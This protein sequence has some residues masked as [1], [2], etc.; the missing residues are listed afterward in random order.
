MSA[1]R[2]RRYLVIRSNG[3]SRVDSGT[4]VFTLKVRGTGELSGSRPPHRGDVLIITLLV[5]VYLPSMDPLSDAPLQTIGP[6]GATAR[7]ITVEPM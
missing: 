1:P 6:L 7:R 5:D 2:P 3:G 4:H